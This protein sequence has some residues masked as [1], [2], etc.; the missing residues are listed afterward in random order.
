MGDDFDIG[1]V[2]AGPAGARAAELLA[3]QGAS[4]V[5]WDPRAPWEKP[6]GG[7]LT[8][9]IFERIPDMIEV[10]PWTRTVRK[11]R[12]ELDPEHG[13]TVPLDAPLRLVSRIDLARWQ[14][15]RAERAGARLEHV[16]VR[17][18]RRTSGGWRVGTSNGHEARVSFLVGA[19]GAASLVRR[20]VAPELRVELVPTRVRYPKGPG[21]EPDLVVM[22]FYDGA[23]GYLWDFPRPDHRSVG[24]GLPGRG[25]GRQRFDREI[26]AYMQ[27]V[28]RC[29][30]GHDSRAGAVIGT[31]WFGHG[32][33]R[34][35]GATD[36]A[37]LG[38]A[39]GFADPTTGEGIQN[40][41]RSADLLAESWREA[42]DFSLYPAKA[43]RAFRTEFR[44]GRFARRALFGNG[45]GT[46]LIGRAMTSTRAYALVAALANASN[47]HS[48]GLRA[49]WRGMLRARASSMED[50]RR[51]RPVARRSVECG[52]GCNAAGGIDGCREDGREASA[53]SR[54]SEPLPA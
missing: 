35:V 32:D 7:G 1:I 46:W 8:A 34:A 38:D 52:C 51:L 30:C 53:R 37:L 23:A 19:D 25:W 27:S 41:L 16:G 4:V 39:A 36:F 17:A 28:E 33:F 49:L 6:C 12:M 48:W 29:D 5:M 15:A 18:L 47:A 21:P 20:V 14:L 31:S 50:E 24:I 40:A 13:F 2:G 22:R 42:G 54:R 45:L 9:S 44:I 11:V 26:D 3:G 43:R 10:L